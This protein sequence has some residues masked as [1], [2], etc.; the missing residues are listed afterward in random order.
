MLRQVTFFHASNLKRDTYRTPSGKY[1]VYDSKSHIYEH[2]RYIPI[3]FRSETLNTDPEVLYL[4]MFLQ[5]MSCLL[6]CFVTSYYNYGSEIY[7]VMCH[8]GYGSDMIF[9]IVQ[10]QYHINFGYRSE[11][12]F[13]IDQI[14]YVPNKCTLD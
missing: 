8:F 2:S 6:Y 4:T 9:E 7:L 5:I 10:H 13:E 12:I 11:T 1:N 14:I 3:I